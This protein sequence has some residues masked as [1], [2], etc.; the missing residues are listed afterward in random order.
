MAHAGTHWRS[1]AELAVGVD[2]DLSGYAARNTVTDRTLHS[3]LKRFPLI[4]KLNLN[5][6]TLISEAGLA[7]VSKLPVLKQLSLR[8][9]RFC[10]LAAAHLDRLSS[11]ETLDFRESHITLDDPPPDASPH[12][13]RARTRLKGKEMD[14]TTLYAGDVRTRHAFGFLLNDSLILFS[15]I[16]D[17]STSYSLICV[18]SCY[19]SLLYIIVY[20]L[21]FFSNVR[22][23][24][25]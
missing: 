22:A 10:T 6:C 12:R 23:H 18:Q 3:I 25:R 5:N 11:L 15:N 21:L 4:E 17:S 9:L 13:Q 2:L 16:D 20:L 1:V 7:A 14:A 24:L 8:K 19:F